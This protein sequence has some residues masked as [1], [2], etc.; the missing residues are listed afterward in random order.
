MRDMI[1]RMA[2]IGGW[3][4]DVRENRAYCTDETYRLLGLEP[5][6]L[7]PNLEV[8]L[9]FV[10]ARDREAIRE[11]IARVLEGEETPPLEFRVVRTDGA[12]RTFWLI[13]EMDRDEEGRPVRIVGFVQDITEPRIVHEKSRTRDEL[14]RLALESAR[15]GTW[16]W[17]I[18]TGQVTWSEGVEDIFGLAPGTFDGTFERYLSLVHPDDLAALQ[19]AIAA[20]LEEDTKYYVE[21]RIVWKDGTIHWLQGRGKMYRDESGRAVRMAGIVADITEQKLQR[22]A[23]RES[24][25]RFRA[26]V[27]HAPEAIVVMEATTGRF[28]DCNTNAEAFF[29]LPRVR[30]LQCD[31]LDVSPTILPD[32]RP[33]EAVARDWIERAVSGEDVTF[34]WVHLDAGGREIP[35]EVRLVRLPARGRILVR[36]SI[37]DITER[38]QAQRERERLIADLEA[39]NAELE[40]FTY[41]VSHDLKSPLVTIKG[42]LGF[43]E[44]DLQANDP[45]R[46]AQDL[47]RIGGAADRMER[48]LGEL[49]QLSRLGRLVNPPEWVELESLVREAVEHVSGAIASRGVSVVIAPGMP[50]VRGDRLRLVE[51]FQN[52]IENAVKFMGDQPEPRVEIGAEPQGED[53]VLC[54]VRDNGQGIDAR[55]HEKVFGLFERLDNRVEGTGVGLAIVKRIVEVHGGRIWVESGEGQ[56]SIFRFVIPRGNDGD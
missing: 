25:A 15:M 52:L 16:N 26:L 24:E 49:L 3:E 23:L 31:P 45:V 53:R 30:L 51:A 43:L 55:Y 41:T 37:T 2:R 8:F 18:R 33:A 28:V 56:G 46:I 35:C 42:F 5:Q 21:H 40:R 50:S 12:V 54:W 39:K 19:E 7:E 38:V 6:S 44:E 4:W 11:Q 34:E 32:G 29:G 10:D 9:R 27:E 17:D 22:E 14:L 48:L 20:A 36:G 1:Y 13:G 47:E